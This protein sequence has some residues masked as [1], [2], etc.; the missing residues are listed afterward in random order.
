MP[1]GEVV[2]LP[3]LYTGL[4]LNRDEFYR[5][6][7]EWERSG[8]SARGIERLEGIVY[9]PTPLPVDSHGEPLAKIVAW[10]GYYM[11][12]TQGAQASCCSTAKLDK[13]NDPECDAILR[14]R[15]G[16]GGQSETDESGYLAGAPEFSV[17]IAGTSSQRDLETKFEI[18]RRNGVL[19][20]LVWETIAEEFHWFVLDDGDYRRLLPDEEGLLRSRVFPGLWL[21]INALLDGDLAKVLQVVQQGLTTDEHQQFVAQLAAKRQ[22]PT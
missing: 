16:F 10:L 15:P 21:D 8:K 19:E 22:A 17:E 20:Y 6:V 12:H 11:A 13:N 9:M 5:R 3:L 1:L 14:I 7:E 4:R 18:Y 2:R